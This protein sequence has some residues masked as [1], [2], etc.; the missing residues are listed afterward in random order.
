MESKF[1]DDILYKQAINRDIQS[2]TDV[3]DLINELFKICEDYWKSKVTL[4]VTTKPELK[5]LLDRSFT[6]WDSFVRRLKKEKWSFSYI[7]EK[8]SY[9][10]IFMQDDKFRD[11]YNNL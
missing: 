11:I 9:K 6:C 5:I 8:Y 10:E 4:G 7:L 3:K 1:L 2:D